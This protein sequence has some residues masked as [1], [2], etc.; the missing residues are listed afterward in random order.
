MPGVTSASALTV[1][2]TV[3]HLQHLR[4]LG[5]DLRSITDEEDVAT[6]ARYLPRSLTTLHLQISWENI[7]FSSEELVD[8][9]RPS[10]SCD[11]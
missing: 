5:F 9:V 8:L 10:P 2:E 1:L 3:A 6:L 4:V 11:C 7:P